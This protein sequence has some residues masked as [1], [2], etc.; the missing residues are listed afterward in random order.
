[1][2]TVP[3]PSATSTLPLFLAAAETAQIPVS[4]AATDVSVICCVNTGVV[5]PALA[6]VIV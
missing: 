2:A 4:V 3:L 1:M 5:S 6:I